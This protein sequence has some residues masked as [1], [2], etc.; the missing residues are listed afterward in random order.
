[1]SQ[2]IKVVRERFLPYFPGMTVK[3]LLTHEELLLILEGK[4]KAF[5]RYGHEIG[6]DGA[7]SS[8]SEVILREV[9]RA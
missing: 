9:E 3:S 6:L 7:L 8:G 1:M 2:P 5:D 4:L